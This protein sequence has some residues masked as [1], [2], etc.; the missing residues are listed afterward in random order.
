MEL[1]EL[2]DLVQSKG[3]ALLVK[4]LQAQVLTRQQT[5]FATPCRSI[6]DTLGQEFMKGEG[7]AFAFVEK[8][9]HIYIDNLSTQ[10]DELS[11]EVNENGN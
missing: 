2:E 11:K 3:W 8:Y 6:D 7:V 10:I 1:R 5:V 9:P 4:M